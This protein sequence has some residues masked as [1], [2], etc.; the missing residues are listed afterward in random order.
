MPNLSSGSTIFIGDKGYVGSPEI[1]AEYKNSKKHPLGAEKVNLNRFLQFFR[2][3]NEHAVAE[4]VQCAYWGLDPWTS[5]L[6]Y[7]SCCLLA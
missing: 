5:G 7:A 6:H 4:M 3:R 2:G 1:I